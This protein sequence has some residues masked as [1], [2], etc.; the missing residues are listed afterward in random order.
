MS[1]SP[2]SF[3]Y[4]QSAP[5]SARIRPDDFAA[6]SLRIQRLAV[7]RFGEAVDNLQLRIAGLGKLLHV[8]AAI[9]ICQT[10]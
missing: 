4:K 7:E 5:F 10:S 8:G 2:Y 3:P 1:T 9:G 6:K